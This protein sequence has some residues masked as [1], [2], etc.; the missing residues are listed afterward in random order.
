MV[1]GAVVAFVLLGGCVGVAP[2][3]EDARAHAAALEFPV[4]AVHPHSFEPLAGPVQ[5]AWS[6]SWFGI[7]AQ[8]EPDLARSTLVQGDV[9][10]TT[11]T[12]MGWTRHAVAPEAAT[13]G[14]SN[15][16]QLW[17][18]RAILADPGVQVH[19]SVAGGRESFEAKGTMRRGDAALA[20]NLTLVAEGGR[21]VQAQVSSPQG[22]ES[23]FDFAP[24]PSPFG[25]A[26]A[27]PPEALVAPNAAFVDTGDARAYDAHSFVSALVADYQF[28]HAQQLP[29]AVDAD[30]LRLE[31]Q[32]AGKPW[33]QAPYG[34]GALHSA[35]ASGQ[36]SWRKCG[37]SD[38]LYT[39]YG[40]D[41][42][43]VLRGYGVGCPLAAPRANP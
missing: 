15:R 8:T 6:G 29:D 9:A 42:P 30:T 22:R 27:Q 13:G 24:S 7:A 17:D 21:V 32:V 2:A 25:I 36:F 33:P 14:V 35:E 26:F 10:F 20:V 39:G 18:L 4:L 16:L 43:L 41:G 38:G 40:W 12:G 5:V 23:P 37:S 31:L 1:R 3:A 11:R 19:S 28:H 34:D